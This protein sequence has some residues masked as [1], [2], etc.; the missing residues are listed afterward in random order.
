MIIEDRDKTPEE[1][2]MEDLQEYFTHVHYED[3]NFI[4]IEDDLDDEYLQLLSASYANR[5]SGQALID[6]L[7]AQE[8]R[9]IY[10]KSLPKNGTLKATNKNRFKKY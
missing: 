7:K 2:F 4:E 1:E 6:T 8:D 5:D 3:E 10:E 9:L